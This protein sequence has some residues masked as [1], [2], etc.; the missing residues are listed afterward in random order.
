MIT[1]ND[2]ELASRLRRFRNHGIDPAARERQRHTEGQWYYEMTELGYN[3]RLPDI[4]C[5]L[6]VTQL[7]K[8]PDNISRRREIVRQYTD[9][10]AELP[11]VVTPVERPEVQSA[12]HLYS[13]RLDLS[14][15][16][17]GRKEV[18]QALR[19]ENIEVNVHYIPVHLHPYYRQ[20][21]GYKGGECPVAEAAYES[22]VT[23]PLF[24]SMTSRDVEDVV[25]AVH[26]VVEHYQVPR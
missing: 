21:F 17:A 22:L 15:L 8:L 13:I 9:A 5:A 7:E 11:G 4:A 10:L 2:A 20:T 26:K 6:G 12:W 23:L 25:D 16:T 19:A 1:T 24:S 18:F 14:K 3:Y